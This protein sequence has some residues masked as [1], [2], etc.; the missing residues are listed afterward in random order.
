MGFGCLVIIPTPLT[1]LAALLPE[2]WNLTESLGGMFMNL[3]LGTGGAIQ[4]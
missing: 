2:G 4:Q 3:G 1:L